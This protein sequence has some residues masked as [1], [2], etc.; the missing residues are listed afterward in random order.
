MKL[1]DIQIL[2]FFFYNDYRRNLIMNF[3][4]NS[5]QSKSN[6]FMM[7]PTVFIGLAETPLSHIRRLSHNRGLF[8]IYFFLQ[9]N[10]CL[11]QISDQ[12]FNYD[13][14]KLFFYK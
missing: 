7:E 11:Q 6:K 1:E 4:L 14:R 3:L 13:I 12:L 5:F 8:S 2:K 9:K 10:N